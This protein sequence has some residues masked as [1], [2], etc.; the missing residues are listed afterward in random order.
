VRP[1]GRTDRLVPYPNRPK[2]EQIRGCP[3]VYANRVD[4]RRLHFGEHV[5]TPFGYLGVN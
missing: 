3:P 2:F 4:L 5:Q 1:P